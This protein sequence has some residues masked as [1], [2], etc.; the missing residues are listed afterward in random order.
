MVGGEHMKN[1][2]RKRYV[3]DLKKNF[4]RYFAIFIML[5]VTIGLMSSFLAVSDGAQIAL[6]QNREEC[7]LED[8]LFSSYQ[9]ISPEI[10]EEIETLGVQVYE[11]FYLD[12][13]LE[14]DSLLRIYKNREYTNLVTVMEGKLPTE[15]DEIAVERLYAENHQIKIGDTLTI[16]GN[17]L[18]ITGFI[19]VPDYSSLFE[20]NSDL[21]MDSFH[22]GLGIVTQENFNRYD[23]DKLIYN[24][25]YYFNNREL[26]GKEQRDL[27]KLI[28]DRLVEKQV[29]LTLFC[30]A[31]NEPD[32]SSEKF[33][34]TSMETYYETGKKNI[35]V[36][37][38]GL[39]EKSKYV[40]ELSNVDFSKG[41]YNYPAGLAVF[42]NQKQLNLMLDYEESHF[43]GYFS[44]ERL[45]FKNESILGMVITPE[46]MVKL[47]DQMTSSFSQMAPMCLGISVIIFLVLMYLLTKMV[48]E[49]N[50]L[51]ISLM[52]VF[53]Y[54][55]TEIR[56]LYLTSTT[57]VVMISLIVSIPLVYITMQFCF[58]AVL[59]K[60]SG[61]I[62]I[63]I[64]W[65]SYGEILLIGFGTYLI[66][67]FFHKK[68][69]DHITMAE[70]LKS[71]E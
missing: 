26:T 63:Y 33:T 8:G 2:L 11:N 19:S 7:K 10:L 53:G 46:D 28:L 44:K 21:M 61:Y 37:F 18:K 51:Y 39:S 66:I 45:N 58:E 56:K 5:M 14:G 40:T 32:S 4:G 68:K 50:A 34:F 48:I 24:Y 16:E 35:E 6:Q 57:V 29:L 52:K 70:A 31:E 23:P 65:Y 1:P 54:E 60:V 22:F 67:N 17:V 59:P 38:Y 42:M 12:E 15:E 47:G 43:N 3:R 49:K 27:S 13:E 30:T 64:P 62:P 25:S 36:S 55:E 9:K 20:K 69:V 71:G 41:V